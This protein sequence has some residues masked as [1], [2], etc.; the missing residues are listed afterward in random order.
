VIPLK[1]IE[2]AKHIV[3]EC[4][5]EHF[6][7]GSILY[8]YFLRFHK[9]ISLFIAEPPKKTYAFL[10]WYE[11]VR[12]QRPSSA[13]LSVS[14][15]LE[16]LELYRF[17]EQNELKINQKMA[18]AFYAAFFEVYDRFLD[19]KCDG[20]IFAILSALI[21]NG[22]EYKVCIDELTQK[23]SLAL[24]RLKAI[25]YKKLLLKENAQLVYIDLCVEDFASSGA[26]WDD[27]LI[28]A[29]EVLNLANVKEV[30]IVNDEDNKKINLKKEV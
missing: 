11:K 8:T 3:I 20:T 24:F 29:K 12:L 14:A 23:E 6:I 19:P 27:T 25:A 1:E 18:T 17:F 30:V 4:D 22:A 10:A 2:R 16:I 5:K 13:D 15:N 28:V 21:E 9:K 7:V 26:T